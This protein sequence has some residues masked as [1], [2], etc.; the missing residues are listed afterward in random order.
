MKPTDFID[1][2]KMLPVHDNLDDMLLDDTPVNGMINYPKNNIYV[3]NYSYH[4]ALLRNLPELI[5]D[6]R[7]NTIA[8]RYPSP[9]KKALV[10]GW[11]RFGINEKYGEYTFLIS[12]IGDTLN[13]LRR[14]SSST[15]IKMSYH[16]EHIQQW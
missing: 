6:P 12:P 10:L 14:I 3:C 7:Y 4:N 16:K 15:G 11:I 13:L 9:Y 5:N 2:V 1:L 8:S